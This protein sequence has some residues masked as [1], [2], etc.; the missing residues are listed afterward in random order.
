M[1]EIVRAHEEYKIC[2]IQH[3]FPRYDYVECGRI[4]F[5]ESGT[6]RLSFRSETLTKNRLRR[7]GTVKTIEAFALV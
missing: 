7:Y 3:T 2:P 5:K 6:I 1:E 4:V